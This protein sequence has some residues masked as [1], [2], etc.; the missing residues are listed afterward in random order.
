MWI[1]SGVGGPL[2]S[3]SDSPIL[4]CLIEGIASCIFRVWNRGM[5][6]LSIRKHGWPPAHCDADG[7]FPQKDE[8]DEA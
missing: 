3:R 5:R 4:T 6:I 1:P 7:D 8:K 2:L